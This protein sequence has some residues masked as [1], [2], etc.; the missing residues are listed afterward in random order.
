MLLSLDTDRIYMEVSCPHCKGSGYVFNPLL[1]RCMQEQVFL[2]PEKE[3]TEWFESKGVKPV[4][5]LPE[6]VPC[7]YCK[8]TGRVKTWVNLRKF[9]LLIAEELKLLILTDK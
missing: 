9:I 2:M 4:F 6:E 7:D 3:R 5:P 1:R 8:G